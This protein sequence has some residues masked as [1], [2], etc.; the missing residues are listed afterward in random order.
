[1]NCVHEPVDASSAKALCRRCGKNIFRIRCYTCGGSGVLESR[2]L[3][4][5]GQCYCHGETL[6][7]TDNHESAFC[8]SCL[9]HA[10]KEKCSGRLECKY[11]HKAIRAIMC[12]DCK[13][14]DQ[15]RLCKR[16]PAQTVY[17][18]RNKIL[19]YVLI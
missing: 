19:C 6:S 17:G 10:P 11:C 13:V 4:W 16:S 3:N 18:C 2:V 9:T 15:N 7:W 12:P 8:D 1:M 5:K 14:P